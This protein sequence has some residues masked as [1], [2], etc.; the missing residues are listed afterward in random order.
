MTKER[1]PVVISLEQALSMTY[2]TLRFAHLGWRVIK[3]EATPRPGQISKGDPNRYIGRPVAGEDRHSYFVAPNVGKEAIALNLKDPAGQE[4][5]HRL[6]TELEADVFCTN[7][8]PIRHQ[9]LGVD[10]PTLS[11]L[12][13][14]LIWCSISA[15]GTAHPEVP[16][17]DPVIQA[18]CGYMDLTGDRDRPPTQCGP[19]LTD[20]KAGDEAFAQVLLAMLERQGSGGGKMIDISMARVAASW[21]H[22]F[23]PLLDMGSEPEELRRNGNKHRQFIPVNAY[24]TSDGFIYVAVGSDAQWIRF[25]SQPMFAGLDQDRF[26]TNESRRADQDELHDLIAEIT[27]RHSRDRVSAALDAASI[28]H[29]PISAIEDV[30]DLDFVAE[31]ATST[32]TPD[33]KVVR[34]PPP[35]VD[36]DHLSEIGG[37]LPFAPSYGEHTDSVLTEAGFGEAELSGLRQ[38]GVIV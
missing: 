1:V 19:P 22:T 18:L 35:A 15:M 28:P 23:T 4:V 14:E 32:E 2:G 26:A 24:P 3:V 8:I 30:A 31:V 20:L 10:Y 6:I 37:K 34:L 12:R 29:S 25:V 21:L 7:T 17:Y 5:L 38:A 11:S 16:G 13:P 33:G 9:P 27:S 36:V